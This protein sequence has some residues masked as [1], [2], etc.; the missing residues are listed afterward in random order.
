M[1]SFGNPIQCYKWKEP[2]RAVDVLACSR[3][4]SAWEGDPEWLEIHTDNEILEL[5]EEDFLFKKDYKLL[6][7]VDNILPAFSY[8]H[9]EY[10]FVPVDD[11]VYF[12]NTNRKPPIYWL[13]RCAYQCVHLP[14]VCNNL[15]KY[16]VYCPVKNNNIKCCG[17]KY[18]IIHREI[19]DI[20]TR[21]KYIQIL[22]AL[23]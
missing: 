1:M 15:T 13:V 17:E 2:I 7:E 10:D 5:Y 20:I 14:N 6:K 21:E 9:G 16:P 18:R 23:K 22:N 8:G 11:A 3:Y 4:P 19:R 12:S